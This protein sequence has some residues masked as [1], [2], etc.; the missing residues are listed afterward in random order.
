MDFLYKH[1]VKLF[2]S[3]TEGNI[4]VKLMD[5]TFT[6][7]QTLGR[8]IYTFQCMAYEVD[9]FTILNCDKYN[10]QQIEDPNNTGE[11]LSYEM[12]YEGQWDETI[13][14]ATEFVHLDPVNDE[15]SILETYYR[16]FERQNYVLKVDHL[17]YLR[18]EI[19]DDPYL[20]YDNG[21]GPQP[22]DNIASPSASVANAAYLGYIAYINGKTIVIPA[23][24]IYELKGDEVAVTS[25]QF[26]KPTNAEIRYYAVII[27]SEDVGK[28][29]ALTTFTDYIG[30][31]WGGFLPGSSLHNKLVTKYFMEHPKDYYQ[32][33]VSINRN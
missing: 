20:I 7:N 14:A 15:Y 18:L 28:I 17:K 10:I 2:R 13:P 11:I 3:A 6:P 29:L 12:D 8:Q 4:L 33:L 5:I 19:Y 31:E 23:D 21:E 30:Q 22:L 16:K 25:L 27:Q 24:G 26:E 32:T 9:D 1:N